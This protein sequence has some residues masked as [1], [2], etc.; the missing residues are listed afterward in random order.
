MSANIL[1]RI[2]ASKREEVAAAKREVPLAELEK[3]ASG[4]PPVRGFAA[5][6]Q[7]RVSERKPAVIAE[8]KRSS[9]SQGVIRADTDVAAVAR[10]YA[11]NGAACLS[12]LTDGPFFGGSRRDLEVARAA[13]ELP[14]IRKDFI[15]DPYQVV[16]A[17]AW[18]ADCIL[19]IV[20]SVPDA[21]LALLE[22]VA[23]KWGLDVLVESHDAA[24]MDRSLSLETP[25]IGVNNRDLRTFETRLETSV[26]L[27]PKV[28]GNRIII[29]ESGIKSIENIRFMQQNGIFA[30]L[31]GGSLMASGNPGAALAGLLGA[32]PKGVAG[33]QHGSGASKAAQGSP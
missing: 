30:F 15:V 20:D 23:R 33:A 26:E 18:G 4:M 16:E 32:E 22:A 24:Q 3:L 9:P 13:C 11:A 6:I 25:L 28:P 31:I 27:A 29:A 7:R 8:I 10:A 2:L 17:R 14:I 5:A 21:E 12:V 19:L 1:E